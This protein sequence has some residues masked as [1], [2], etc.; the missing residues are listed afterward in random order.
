M[1]TLRMYAYLCGTDE[2]FASTIHPDKG[3]MRSRAPRTTEWSCAGSL[4]SC[5]SLQQEAISGLDPSK[6]LRESHVAISGQV[7]DRDRERA[8]PT[9]GL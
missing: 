1:T 8:V 7:P 6:H 2:G 9:A 3:V 5:H 4:L